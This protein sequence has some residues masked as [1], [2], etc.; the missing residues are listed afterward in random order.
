MGQQEK[1]VDVLDTI[2]SSSQE[3]LI[4]I[5]EADYMLRM[6]E[7]NHLMGNILE[8]GKHYFPDKFTLPFCRELHDYLV[9]IRHEPQDATHAPRGYAK[10]TIKCFLIPIYQALN[11]PESYSHYLNI[12][13]TSTKSVAINLSIRVELET[14]EQL[15]ND[16][17]LQYADGL[18]WTEKQFQLVNGVIFTARGVG[19]SIRGI[20][21]N[22]V[23]PDYIIGDDLYDDDD[24]YNLNRIEK[25]E[26]Y[27]WGS[28]Y[29]ALAKGKHTCFHIQGTA[30]HPK[31]IIHKLSTNDA[32]NYRKFQAVT[33]WDKKLVLWPEA[34]TYEKLMEDKEQMGSTIFNREMQNECRDDETA[35]IKESWIKYYD[36]EILNP[37]TDTVIKKVGTLDPAISLSKTSDFSGKA[38]VKITRNGNFYI[39]DIKEDKLSV[40]QNIDDVENWHIRHKFD[41][42]KVEAI[43]GFR[44][45]SEGLIE[46]GQVPIKEITKVL[47]K[48]IR[49]EAQSAKFENGKV[50]INTQI[51]DR[52]RNRLVEQLIN[53]VPVND[54]LSD[55]VMLALEEPQKL[56]SFGFLDS[57][58]SQNTSIKGYDV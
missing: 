42:F 58:E 38:Y 46:R 26:R 41:I 24:M 4:S 33:D 47:G 39:H 37:N 29:K 23:R 32:W 7:T 31:D 34:E 48:E 17:G 5:D 12:Q 2:Q 40:K 3:G 55:A 45:I 8:W 25:I 28:V 43:S 15:I 57:D 6:I 36:G 44:A 50:F 22:N 16:Y 35:I 53:N 30:I 56:T 14:N 20:N 49:K 11:E 51:P 19:D 21:H 27:V 9:S 54:D 10:T 18:K 52:L 13:S 1:L